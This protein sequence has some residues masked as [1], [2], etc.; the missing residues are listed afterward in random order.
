M[1]LSV[2]SPILYLLVY[3][4]NVFTLASYCPASQVLNFDLQYGYPVDIFEEDFRTKYSRKHLLDCW[5]RGANSTYDVHHNCTMNDV[6]CPI[7]SANLHLLIKQ[8]SNATL[9]RFYQSLNSI[10][11]NPRVVAYGGSV[12]VGSG[13]EGGIRNDSTVRSPWLS[14]LGDWLNIT[15]PN[16]IRGYNLGYAA[17]NSY[18]MQDIVIEFTKK[19][20]IRQFEFSDIIFL[21]FAMNDNICSLAAEVHQLQVGIES[22]IRKIYLISSQTDPPTIVLLDGMASTMMTGYCS[23]RYIEVYQ[24]IALHYNLVYWSYRDA[25]TLA[26]Y[27]SRS[28]KTFEPY[29]KWQ[30]NTLNNA[31]PS[32]FLQLF[33]ADLYAGALIDGFQKCKAIPSAA[34]T[35]LSLPPPLYSDTD[36]HCQRD[37]QPLLSINYESLHEGRYSDVVGLYRSVPVNA[38]LLREDVKGKGGFVRELNYSSPAYPIPYNEFDARLVFTLNMTQLSVEEVLKLGK[39]VHLKVEYLR[40]YHNAGVAD[41]YFCGQRILFHIAH[42]VTPI[43]AL[44]VDYQHFKYSLPS[45]LIH[46]LDFHACLS[47]NSSSVPT[48][49]IVHRNA[50]NESSLHLPALHH[51]AKIGES[52]VSDGSVRGNQKVK[53]TSVSICITSKI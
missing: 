25:V 7:S 18:R 38:W 15:Y 53:I 44:W 27:T 47:N 41:V 21:D 17:H 19:N 29:V 52:F 49:E 33:T 36:L 34:A 50:L 23:M 1:H 14:Y 42:R 2:M 32:W 9:C 6:S 16:R 26:N 11:N 30:L 39:L 22:M 12:T 28:Q 37:Y 8:P 51:K 35:P 40:T 4:A 31:H 3:L 46:Q 48:L 20:G 24:K 43:D 45:V 5:V 13:S 10:T